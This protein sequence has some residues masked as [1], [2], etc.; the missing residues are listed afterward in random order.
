MWIVA[1]LGLLG[2]ALASAVSIRKITGGMTPYDVPVA[3]TL[4]K[5]PS[6]ALTAVAGILLLG[7]GFVPGLSDLDSQRQ[8]LAYALV[9]GYAQQL[10]TQFIDKRAETLLA[11]VPSKHAKNPPTKSIPQPATAA[12]PVDSTTN[13]RSPAYATD[14]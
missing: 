14:G 12:P 5:V 1:G 2:G 7:G 3:L 8:I 9:F 13:G 10:A 6:G 4:L 11:Q